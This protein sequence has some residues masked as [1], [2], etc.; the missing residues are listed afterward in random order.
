MTSSDLERNQ[1]AEEYEDVA[2]SK[3]SSETQYT[4]AEEKRALQKLDWT[5]IPL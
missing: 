5:L 4:P 2:V 3:A 1:M